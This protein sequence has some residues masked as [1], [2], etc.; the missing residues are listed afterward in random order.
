M[1]KRLTEREALALTDRDIVRRASEQHMEMTGKVM[2]PSSHHNGDIE[3][4]GAGIQVDQEDTQR[5]RAVCY[6][7]EE[8]V[9]AVEDLSDLNWAVDHY[10]LIG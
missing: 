10:E 9:N 7:S 8:A 1:S 2:D 5:L 3:F 6:Q 4:A